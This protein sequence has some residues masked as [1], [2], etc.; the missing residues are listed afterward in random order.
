MFRQ[1]EGQL[2]PSPASGSASSSA[3][4]TS[5]RSSSHLQTLT[6][7]KN[8]SPA[9][10]MMATRMTNGGASH[11]PAPY[12]PASQQ[13]YIPPP[14]FHVT[15]LSGTKPKPG[16]WTPSGTT[17]K[18]MTITAPSNVQVQPN[19]DSSFTMSFGINVDDAG[20]KENQ[21]PSSISPR[22][23]MFKVSKQGNVENPTQA[24]KPSPSALSNIQSQPHQ[25]NP[26]KSIPDNSPF[27]QFRQG[28][29]ETDDLPA[30]APDVKV[31]DLTSILK[32]GSS[33]MEDAPDSPSGKSKRQYRFQHSHVRHIE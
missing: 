9:A 1:L 20:S 14:M 32:G 19:A 2:Q 22:P 16:V 4:H 29:M 26:L 18:G 17:Q 15:N 12:I 25:I 11:S 3:Q 7:F 23:A 10:D 6:P 24:W 33:M 13:N 8:P 28:Y 5:A 21:P 27:H 31:F 30:L